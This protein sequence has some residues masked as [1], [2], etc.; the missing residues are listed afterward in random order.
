MKRL[1]FILG[2][3]AF[4]PLL[5]FG[6]ELV[7]TPA[8][9]SGES[10]HT[11][12]VVSMPIDCRKAFTV[13]KLVD[14]PALQGLMY[15]ALGWVRDAAADPT[16]TVTVTAQGGRLV[17]GAFSADDSEPETLLPA[18]EGEGTF[19]WHVVELSKKVF[20]LTHTVKKNTVV[21]ASA[22]LYGY[23]DFT[24]C[25]GRASQADVEAAVLRTG[26]YRLSVVQDELW[27][28]QPINVAQTRSGIKTDSSLGQ[29]V[30][31]TTAFAFTGCGNLRYDYALAGGALE[32]SVDGLIVATYDAPTAGWTFVQVELANDGAH[33]IVFRYTAAGGGA[34]AA[35]RDVYVRQSDGDWMEGV[36]PNVRADLRT[37]VRAPKRLAQ[38][39]P[40]QYSSTNWVGDV[41]GARATS[42][43]K[44]TIVQLTGD[45]PDVAKWTTELPET[46]KVLKEGIGEG[47]V[48][49]KAKKGVWKATFEILNDAKS[50]HKETVI[51]DLRDSSSNGLL[52]F[53]TRAIFRRNGLPFENSM[54]QMG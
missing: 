11:D 7:P 24:A 19:D 32:V 4:A 15:S 50:I 30:S 41:A 40:F 1:N 8:Y 12:I 21:D 27:P 9:W 6:D 34:T 37:G 53:V 54:E 17:N 25:E 33:E 3:L 14:E 10:D 44:V 36:L 5:A 42:V 49:W 46:T 2:T 29:G 43:A 16:R 18:T 51:F 45:D 35:I 23:L 26:S 20:R 52:I 38:V 47:E 31:T 39:L 48:P 22:T 13:A 28:W